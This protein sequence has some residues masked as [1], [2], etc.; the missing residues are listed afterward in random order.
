VTAKALGLLT[1]GGWIENDAG[2]HREIV[3]E[4]RAWPSRIKRG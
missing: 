3:G 2:A 4:K 1:F